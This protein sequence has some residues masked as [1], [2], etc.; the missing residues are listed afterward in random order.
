MIWERGVETGRKNTPR[1]RMGLAHWE[2][3]GFPSTPKG[4][5]APV[6]SSSCSEFALL[7]SGIEI[8]FIEE[9]MAVSY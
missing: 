5:M 3:L 7:T 9:R 2:G 1:I 4:V 6:N 8:D